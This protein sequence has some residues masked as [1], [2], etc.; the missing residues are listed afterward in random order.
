MTVVTTPQVRAELMA[1]APDGV[2]SGKT[3]W[4][5]LEIRHQPEW[6]TYW[7]NPGDSGLPT[8]LEWT[9]PP[10]VLAGDIA[11]PLPKKI[12][13]ARLINYGYEGTVLLPV[14]LTITPDFKPSLLSP[15]LVVKLKASW[16]VCRQ[17]CIPEEGEFLLKVPVKSSTALNAAAFDA[18]LAAQ[19]KPLPVN[20]AS[21]IAIKGQTLELTMDGLPAS[22]RG[23]TLEAFPE[24]PEV[25]NPSAP[26]KQ[27]WQGERWSA[28]L[29]LSN[30]RNAS[31][32]KLPVVLTYKGQGWRTELPVSGQWPKVIVAAALSPPLQPS[33]PANIAAGSTVSLTF[34]AALLGALIGGLILNLMPCVFPILAIKVLSFT[35]HADDHRSHRLSGLA[36][37]AGVV[38]SFVLLGLLL[39]GLRAGGESLGWGF[40]LQSPGVVAGLDRKSVV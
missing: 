17:E 21:G 23:Q 12:A 27:A 18:A 10:G 36:Y 34:M 33:V 7:K 11:W 40:Q 37:A 8:V 9:L 13:L 14:P 2:E 30:E 38:V 19:P 4:L 31:P 5:G 35:R 1:Q 3:V 16:L 20:K 25:I 29:P 15:D 26:W 24:T 6:H 39:L 28:E 22:L 32:T